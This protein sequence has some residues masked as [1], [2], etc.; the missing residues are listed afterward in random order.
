[1]AFFFFKLLQQII[2]SKINTD[3]GHVNSVDLFVINIVDFKENG[4]DHI[5]M[6]IKLQMTKK[7]TKNKQ[8]LI[9]LKNKAMQ[10]NA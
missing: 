2:F 10:R 9:L 3:I 8:T 7:I 5:I 4:T 6:V 1:M